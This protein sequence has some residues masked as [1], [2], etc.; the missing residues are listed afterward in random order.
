MY[1]KNIKD[2]KGDKTM[3]KLFK[4]TLAAALS[5]AMTAA[6]ISTGGVTTKAATPTSSVTTTS[7]GT[8]TVSVEKFTIGQGYVL[9]PVQVKLESG[10]TAD[11]VFD[12]AMKTAGITY[13]A[14]STYGFYLTSIN[15]AD[16]KN[17]N[18]P[19]RISDM[20]SYSSKFASYEPPS[21]IKNDGNSLPD[22]ALGEYS[23]NGMAGWLFTIN[24]EIGSTSIDKVEVKSGDVIRCQFS[25]YGWGADIGSSANT[26]YTGIHAIPAVAKE[27][28]TK[29]AASVNSKK[30]DWAN[31]ETVKTAYNNAIS[32][33]SNFDLTQ[34]NVDAALEVLVQA[35]KTIVIPDETTTPPET[36]TYPK[37][38][39]ASI[40]K[41]KNIKVRKAKI[42]IKKM[43]SVSGYQIKYSTSK[44]FKAKYTKTKN[45]SKITFVTKKLKKGKRCYVKVRAY[46]KV[47]KTKVYGKW[48]KVKSVKI[49]K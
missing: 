7:A 16:S 27:A 3:K 33:L 25:V 1:T 5:L 17:V 45:T 15:N 48:S 13:S 28:L 39:K 26:E 29:V 14:S 44:K 11:K 36:T 35:E 37:V 38:K 32:I 20:E 34:A 40:K 18:I 10:D 23:Y 47:N 19:Q 6:V 41:V 22:N 30:A 12:K 8:A 31:N 4:K 42:S 9:E 46:V 49:K 43:K 21:N 24:G 2:R